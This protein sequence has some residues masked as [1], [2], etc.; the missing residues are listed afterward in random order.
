MNE[1][2]ELN[3]EELDH[4]SGGG[5][6]ETVQRVLNAVGNTVVGLIGAGLGALGGGGIGGGSGSSG[7]GCNGT[8]GCYPL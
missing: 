5:P 1:I 4:V 6:V 8:N 3:L 7:G 2:I